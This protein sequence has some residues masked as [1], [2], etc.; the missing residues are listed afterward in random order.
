M[1]FSIATSDLNQHAIKTLNHT[2]IHLAESY[3]YFEIWF[4]NRLK[5][6]THIQHLTQQISCIVMLLHQHCKS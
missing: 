4:G 2:H 5:F 6:K 1:I 3:K